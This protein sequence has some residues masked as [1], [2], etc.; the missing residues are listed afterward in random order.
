MT[1]VFHNREDLER[2]MLLLNNKVLIQPFVDLNPEY[3][4]VFFNMSFSHGFKRTAKGFPMTYEN[5]NRE[6]WYPTE[7]NVE[8]GKTVLT[9]CEKITGKRPLVARI[10]FFNDMTLTEIELIEPDLQ[11]DHNGIDLFVR[12]L[13]QLL[14]DQTF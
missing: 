3:S 14:Y 1:G 13:S 4:M 11:L 12:A 6:K 7:N 9:C 2:H 8:W 5:T 10:D